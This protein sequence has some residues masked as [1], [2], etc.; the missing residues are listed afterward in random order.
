MLRSVFTG[1]AAWHSAARN[2]LK[3]CSPTSKMR[4]SGRASRRPR[5]GITHPASPLSSAGRTV[6]S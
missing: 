4:G 6:D 2:E 1:D 5:A 3:S